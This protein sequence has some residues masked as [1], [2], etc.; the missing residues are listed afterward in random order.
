MN[1]DGN[2]Q[3]RAHDTVHNR[4]TRRT[5]AASIW[6]VVVHEPTTRYHKDGL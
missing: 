1:G 5:L 3:D 2:V 4:T 6:D